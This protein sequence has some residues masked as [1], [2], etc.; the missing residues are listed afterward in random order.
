MEKIV[1]FYNDKTEE[2]NL[3]LEEGYTVKSIT[4]TSEFV[5]CSTGSS[6]SGYVSSQ[7]N[8]GRILTIVILEKKYITN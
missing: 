4:S 7:T 5:A 6:S 2:L 8:T 3:L 1:T